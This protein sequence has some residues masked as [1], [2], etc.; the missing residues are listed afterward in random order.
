MYGTKFLKFMLQDE[1]SGGLERHSNGF[2]MYVKRGWTH[3]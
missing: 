1:T 2:R 3:S